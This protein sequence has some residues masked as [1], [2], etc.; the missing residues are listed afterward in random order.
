MSETTADRG[1]GRRITR[2]G[3]FLTLSGIVCK[4]LLLVYTVIAVE[5]LGKE[6]FG[7]LE[8][9]FEI[10]IIFSVLADFGLEQTVT[11]EL[12]RSRAG[13]FARIYPLFSYRMAVSIAGSAVMLG[14]FWLTRREGHTWGLMAAAVVY[15]FIVSHG[16]LIRA[17]ARSLEW[18]TLESWANVLDKAVQIGLALIVL[19]WYPKLPVLLLCYG[20][21]VFAAL[22]L[23]WWRFLR[24]FGWHPRPYALAE[25]A[26]WQRMAVPLGL[27]AACILLLHREDTVMVNWIRGDEET[28][29]YRAPYRFLEGLFLFPQVLAI[30]AYPVFSR[31]HHDG[32]PF[33][34]TAALL[35][36]GLILISLPIAAG[37]ACVAHG[38]MMTLTPDLGPAGGWVFAILVWSLPFIYVNFLLG[39][40]LNATNRQRYNF[41]ASAWGLVMN[42]ALNVPA[43]YWH[44]AYGAALV[45]A[46][47]QAGYGAAMLLYLRDFHWRPVW[48]RYAGI[49]ASAAAMSAVL[50]WTQPAWYFAIPLGAAVYGVLVVVLRGVTLEDMRNIRRVVRGN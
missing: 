24:E 34:G 38:M 22:V 32:Q 3:M 31:L 2:H 5:L 41:Y 26:R 33:G 9:F 49:G 27:S 48:R 39:T 36:R 13:L 42:A 16:M 44:G 21:G 12:A 23:Y 19:Y 28:G 11:R 47:S 46:V 6:R 15:F 20:A 50:L 35:L 30:S 1:V 8:Y 45:T 18:L 10:A 25:W 17:A 4:I 7:R 37:G 40:I 14:F 43:I 29:L